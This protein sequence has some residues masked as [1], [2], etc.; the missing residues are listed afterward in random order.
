[1][2]AEDLAVA[3]QF[4]D[5]LAAA[6]KSGDLQAVYPLLDPDVHWMT[7]QRDLRGVAEVA[8][9][10]SWF[11]PDEV[12]HEVDFEIEEPTDLGGGKIATNF[13]EI[14]RT[15]QTGEFAYSRDRRIVLTICEGKIASYE[16]RFED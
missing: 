12:R 1:M 3:R 10:F 11:S 7:P 2:G 6:A 13:Q 9:L 8:T 5:T 15:Q 14:Y 4:F 16:M